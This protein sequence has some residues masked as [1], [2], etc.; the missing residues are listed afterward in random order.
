M[1]DPILQLREALAGRYA[2][3]REIGSGGAAVVYLARDQRHERLVALKVLRPELAASLSAERFLREIKIAAGLTHPH[4]LPIHDSGEAAGLLYY[5]MPYVE[6]ES[7]KA[8]LQR[9]GPLPVEDALRIAREVADALRYAHSQGVVHRDIKPGNIL[10][11]GGHAVVADFGIA[12]A[13]GAEAETLTEAGLVIGTPAYMSPEQARGGTV[14]DGRTDL[15]SLGCVL[16]EML[17]GHPPFTGPTSQ[18][19]LMQHSSDPPV[20]VRTRRASVPIEIDRAVARLLAKLPA[21]RFSTADQFLAATPAE[22]AE[23]APPGGPRARVRS[24]ALGA[25]V[26]L[27]AMIAAGAALVRSTGRHPGPVGVVVLPFETPGGA[28]SAGSPGDGAA[29]LTLGRTLEWMPGLNAI[30]GSPLVGDGASWRR[31][32][33]PELLREARRAGGKYLLAGTMTPGRGSVRLGIDI[34]A[35]AGGD[36][37][38]RAED[39]ATAGHLEA[40][41]AQLALASAEALAER[42]GLGTGGRRSLFAATRSPAALG[43]LVQGQRRFWTGD[44]RGA[45]DAFT[46][47]VA[48]DSDCGLAYHRLSVAEEWAHDWNA[49]L[50]TVAA[51]LDRRDRIAPRWVALLRGRYY[52]LTGQ[53]DSAIA[54]FQEAVLDHRDDV[55]AWMGLA[56]SLFHF[57]GYAGHRLADAR[58]AFERM[59]E[60]DSAFAPNYSH[61]VDLALQERD[62]ARARK[63]VA[64]MYRDDPARPAREVAL[65]LR[66]GDARHRSAALV[67]AARLDRTGIAD[68]AALW[69]QPGFD[70]ALAD[71]LARLLVVGPNATPADR[72]RGGQLRLLALAAS[73]RGAE[74]IRAWQDAAGESRYDGYVVQAY[75]AGYPAGGR[76]AP[77]LEWARQLLRDGRAPDFA[78]QPWEEVQQAFLGLV[79]EATLRGDSVQVGRLLRALG[80]RPADADSAFPV[81]GALQASLEARLAL[82]ARDTALAIGRLERA[83]G[84]VPEPWTRYY[85]LTALAPQRLLLAELLAAR[86]RAAEARRWLESFSNTW[87]AGDV[88]YRARAERLRARLSR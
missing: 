7:L 30:D 64:R 11:V 24:R 35:V 59:A 23:G 49:A 47:A 83:L 48:A 20:P 50:R 15:Y 44:F 16:Y 62:E 76:A 66:F 12:T 4:I 80:P 55:D 79:H 71:S 84:H 25:A 10:L 39:S 53:G 26:A 54:T 8:R 60:L 81:S 87:S 22:R 38:L 40:A 86:G 78:R 57:G 19:V 69:M 45:A 18:A 32:A 72:E 33:L 73:G 56:E 27:A 31:I 1:R 88:L 21:D 58:P 67:R 3:E 65:D 85:P 17:T 42:E 14:V 51:G 70:L 52:Y 77:M 74:G 9:E 46:A 75:L 37:V 63:Y 41:L 43:Y 61:L 5:V 82:L 13:I 29:H 34:Y 6:G 2:L 28:A 68:L 36:R